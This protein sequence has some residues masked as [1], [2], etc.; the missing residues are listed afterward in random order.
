MGN[1]NERL[2]MANSQK[3]LDF[4]KLTEEEK[5]AI[6]RENRRE[7]KAEIVQIALILLV[8]ALAVWFLNQVF[9]WMQS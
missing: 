3:Q 8:G 6:R 1:V 2:N 9:I 7:L 5:E 4:L